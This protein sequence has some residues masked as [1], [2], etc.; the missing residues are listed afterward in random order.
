VTAQLWIG[1]GFLSLLIAFLIVSFFFTPKLT[2]DQ[3]G[4]LKLISALCAGFSG[5]FLTGSAL[6]E[7][8]KTAGS[9]TFAISGTAGCALFFVVWFFYPRVFKIA[10]AFAFN[11]GQNWTF[12]DTADQM[13]RS[14]NSVVDPVAFRPDE[15]KAAMQS[16][17]V[18]TTS[19]REALAQLRYLTVEANAVRPYDV[20]QDGSMYRLNIL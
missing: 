6:F 16:R 13:A 18:S 8:H 3:R 9:T 10:D 14:R 12:R 19:L 15:L 17:G 2:D 7:M 20:T 4:T 11:I 1:F 5:G